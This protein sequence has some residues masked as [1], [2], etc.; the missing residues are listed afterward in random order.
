MLAQLRP[1]IILLASFTFL[2]GLVYP[3][4]VT[5]VAQA[6]MPEQANGSLMRAGGRVL[7]SRLIGQPFDAPKYFWGRLST[8]P[9]FP[10]NAA[11]SSGSNLGPSNEAL[12]KAA[13]ARVE[14]LR[15]ADPDNQA[16]IP[17][18][19]V[20]A[21]ASGLDP[22]ISVAAALYQAPR[23][24]RERGRSPDDVASL[25]ERATEDLQFGWLGQRRVNVLRLNLALDGPLELPAVSPPLRLPSRGFG[26]SPFRPLRP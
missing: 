19:L 5:A 12:V 2:L 22:H 24:A 1:A 13:R 15:R 7:G 16:L 8:T 11:A 20:T 23:V 21:S 17:V 18:D 4:A 10:Y 14:A 3:L 6:L 26:P 9:Q 25:I